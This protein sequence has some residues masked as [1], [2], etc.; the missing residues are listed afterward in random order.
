MKRV[1]HPWNMWEDHQH[2]FYGGQEYPKNATEVYA[3]LLK[4]LPRFESA[5]TVIVNSWPYSCEHN[6]TN[7]AMNRIAYL[8]QASCALVY[9]VPSSVSMGGYN[10]LTKDEQIAADALAK[11]YLDLWEASYKEMI[12]V[13]SKEVS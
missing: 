9:N 6:L 5:L 7:T 11:K 12:N 10:L 2:N 1:Y 8:G 13:D 4:D 3:S